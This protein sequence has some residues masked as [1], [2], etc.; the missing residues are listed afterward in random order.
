MPLLS[1]RRA[2]GGSNGTAGDVDC[3]LVTSTDTAAVSRLAA[4]GGNDAAV[5]GK[6]PA[7]EDAVTRTPIN[8]RRAAD[9]GDGAAGD[10][11]AACCLN[12][13]RHLAGAAGGFDGAAVD[14]KVAIAIETDAAAPEFR[15]AARDDERAAALDGQAASGIN[16]EAAALV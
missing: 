1:L 11:G 6:A 4:R 5:N 12:A 16:A 9:G 14:G 13:V 2:A 7:C 10:G 15:R 3:L 8:C